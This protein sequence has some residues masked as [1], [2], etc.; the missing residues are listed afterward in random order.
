MSEPHYVTYEESVRWLRAQPQWQQLVK[1]SYLDEDLVGA[2]RRFA[3]SEEFEAVANL[4]KLH[5]TCGVAQKVLDVGCGNGIA[6]FAFASLGH[7]VVAVDPD[8]SAQVGLGAISQLTA[9]LDQKLGGT[10][11][12]LAGFAESLPLETASFDVVY[13]RQA[14]HHFSDLRAGIA[15]CARV[16]KPGG[17]FLATREHVVSDEAQL[18]QFLDNHPLHAQHGGENAHPLAR[19]LEAFRVA[20]LKIEHVLAP[21]DSVIN[22]FPESNAHIRAQIETALRKRLG[23]AAPLLARTRFTQRLG[24]AAFSRRC[25]YPGRLYSFLAVKPKAA[26]R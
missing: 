20:G 5:S 18:Q 2:A 17:L 10:I 1:D 9:A 23:P 8:T 14:L 26:T 13:A 6:S 11:S 4:L 12:P 7:E 22:H 24:R 25:D 16:L 19:Y 21:Y 3:G 15:D